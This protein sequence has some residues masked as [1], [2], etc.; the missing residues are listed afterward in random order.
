MNIN[1][2]LTSVK[3]VGAKTAG[4]LQA[5][6]ILT[7]KDLLYFLPRDYEQYQNI[8]QIRDLKPGKVVLK[9]K[10]ENLAISRKRRGLTMV[11]ASVY[12]D[13]G[14]VK[15]IWFN[16]PYR[17]KQFAPAKEY[18][19]SGELQFMYGRYSLVNPSAA[20]AAEY[21]TAQDKYSPVYKSAGALKPNI[22]Q[23][24][25]HSMKPLFHQIPENLPPIAGLL[26]RSEAL[27]LAHFPE[28]DQ[29][30][31]RGRER[32]A[33]EELFEIMLASALNRRENASLSAP[34]IP[35]HQALT[36]DFVQKLPF[37][38]TNAQRRAAWEI[39]KDMEKSTP[40]NRLLQG[41]VGSG[42]T[43]VAA[44][45]ALGA[46]H[47][48]F[49]V[50]LMAPTEILA[51]QHFTSLQ[52][53]HLPARLLVGS[54]KHKADLHAAIKTGEANLIV[55]THALIAEKV[56]FQNLGLVIIDEQHRFGVRQ[57]QKLL[58]HGAKMPHLLSMTATP[59]PRSL[60]LTLF[61][62]LDMSILDELP[63]GRQ[64]I[65]TQIISPNSL[66]PM[67]AKVASE[68]QQNRQVY[69]VCPAITDDKA[70]DLKNVEK[71]YASLKRKFGSVGLLHGKIPAPKKAQTIQDFASG[72]I[73]LLVSTTVVEVGVDVPNAS[74]III[75]DADRFGLAQLH[76]L[77][78]RVGRGAHQSYC[79]LVTSD[80][81]KP[82]RRLR[83]IAKSNDGFYLA[84]KD[85]E[86]R[87]P[88]EIYGSMQHGALNLKIAT[89]T[90]TKL[91]AR[92][93]TAVQNFLSS[94]E[95]LENYPEL[96]T[97]VQK[98][99]RMTTLN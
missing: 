80:S 76:Q 25:L 27:F 79:F 85:L 32:L 96:L 5:A 62:E 53:L 56:K 29:D 64:P 99:Q 83:E 93:Q 88:G 37:H 67:F 44:L 48:G 54:A 1:L 13:S 61:S 95:K 81:Q 70:T 84:Q 42:K 60:Q 45:A 69:Y 8:T 43:V 14:A 51:M 22:T 2:P 6:G 10:V 72:K 19:F 24:I 65:Q 34:E 73:S 31:Q 98:Y 46:L 97:A 52:N 41:D 36:R 18:Y 55:G 94:G 66:D 82:T 74:V 33:F 11:E 91:L 68:I 35:F 50:A 26:P 39:L 71:E 3:G 40:M 57:R 17:V 92:V 89:I 23:K 20:S 49:Q 75:R 15:V 21:E 30:V 28:N 16:Q 77:R 47:A 59:I 7:I 86:L 63:K 90:D 58:T 78:G 9:G 12:D 87:G 4:L 38:L